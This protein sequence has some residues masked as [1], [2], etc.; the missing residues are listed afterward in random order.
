MENELIYDT[1]S[2]LFPRGK[3][4]VRAIALQPAFKCP[5]QI[6]LKSREKGL[7]KDFVC[8]RNDCINKDRSLC[9]HNN[10]DF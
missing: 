9:L 4:K 8:Y 5:V 6:K 7:L 2:C 10:E 3:G 1:L